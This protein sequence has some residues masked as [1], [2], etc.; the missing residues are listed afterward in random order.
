MTA[1][2]HT[3]RPDEVVERFDAPD[4]TS[5]VVAVAWPTGRPIHRYTAAELA[6][7]VDLYTRAMKARAAGVTHRG[8][9]DAPQR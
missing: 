7:G 2:R 5:T 8:E 9:H 1:N 6:E 4:E 3:S